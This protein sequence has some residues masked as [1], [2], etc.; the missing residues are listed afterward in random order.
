MPDED[1]KEET[2]VV[3]MTAE[4]KAKAEVMAIAKEF[5]DD[6][7]AMEVKARSMGTSILTVLI[8]AGRNLLG[9]DLHTPKTTEEPAKK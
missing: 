6:L 4:E 3:E 1:K 2:A 9:V 8:H 5:S 7:I